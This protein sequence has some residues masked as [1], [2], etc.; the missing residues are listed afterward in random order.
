MANVKGKLKRK[1]GDILLPHTTAD[2]VTLSAA[3]TTYAA[4]SSVQAAIAG[5]DTRVSS[6]PS[7]LVASVNGETGTVVLDAS[8][9]KLSAATTTYTTSDS[10]QNAIAGL[11]TRVGTN[12][13]NI[14]TL[15]G[16]AVKSVNGVTP[17]NGAVNIYGTNVK[18]TSASGAIAIIDSGGKIPVTLLP[19]AILG[20]VMY[21]G[22][23]V[24]SFN[25]AT[26]AI[27]SIT[28]TTELA[29]LLEISQTSSTWSQVTSAINGNVLT[30]NGGVYFIIAAPQNSTGPYAEASIDFVSGTTHNVLA[31][32]PGDWVIYDG[33]D[34]YQKIDNTD[35]VK[36]VNN[37]APTAGN[38]TLTGNDITNGTAV[39]GPSGATLGASSASVRT[40][41][42]ALADAT[43]YFEADS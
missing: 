4:D 29:N 26:P 18:A 11:D 37:V 33:N 6:L 25:T 20:Q 3:T 35:T 32:E 41:I 12:A 30:R 27:S 39:T 16:A 13:S 36:T 23:I 24:I 17:T 1:N 28:L 38:I 10:V 2:I 7:T 19:D 22:S 15:D 14:S 31:V 42:Q 21:G 34:L 8:E 5:L 40:T 43:L 9:I